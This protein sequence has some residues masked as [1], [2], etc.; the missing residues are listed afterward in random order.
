[1][2]RVNAMCLSFVVLFM[3]A[4]ASLT[5][6]AEEISLEITDCQ[7]KTTQ[8]KPTEDVGVVF[9]WGEGMI[10]VLWSDIQKVV[11]PCPK[12]EIVE[13]VEKMAIFFSEQPVEITYKNGDVK[14]LNYKWFAEAALIILT[15]NRS[16]DCLIYTL[17]V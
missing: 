9:S 12:S 7:G 3:M 6:S 10:T 16:L 1:M 5:V 14:K 4:G 17:P 8:V 15:A 2:K 13:T 11:F